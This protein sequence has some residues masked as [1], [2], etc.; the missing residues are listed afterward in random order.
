MFILTNPNLSL[1]LPS[2]PDFEIES[3]STMPQP[4]PSYSE[5]V[6]PVSQPPQLTSKYSRAM[7]IFK[8]IMA[9][10][11]KEE[12][13]QEREDSQS[14]EFHVIFQDGKMDIIVEDWDSERHG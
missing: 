1:L 4:Q 13:R 2:A 11:Q 5:G 10:K 6:P 14:R 3:Y 12:P 9:S 8:S 7:Q